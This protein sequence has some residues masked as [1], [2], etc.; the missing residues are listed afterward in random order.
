MSISGIFFHK[1]EHVEVRVNDVDFTV[2]MNHKK[3]ADLMVE[4]S[5]KHICIY[6]CVS[7]F[8]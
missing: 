8:K 3:T 4:K 6:N 1:F 7:K 5:C 2:I